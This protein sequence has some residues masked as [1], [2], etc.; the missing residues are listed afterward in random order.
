MLISCLLGFAVFVLISFLGVNYLSGAQTLYLGFSSSP[1]TP[2][3]PQYSVSF[4]V[5]PY[6]WVVVGAIVFAVALAAGYS[7]DERLGWIIFSVLLGG[8]EMVLGYFLFESIAL[9]LGF[10]TASLEVPINAGQV[11]VGLMVAI[12]VVRSY[13]RIARR[14]VP[15]RAVAKA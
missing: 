1:T 10:V 11:L 14:G 5:P 4:F 7:L 3:G 8:S 6:L 9:Q 15:S 2:L 13:R 12:P